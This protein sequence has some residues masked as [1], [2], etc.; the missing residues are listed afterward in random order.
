MPTVLRVFCVSC[1]RETN[2]SA[3]HEVKKN[4]NDEEAEIWAEGKWQIIQCNGCDAIS[5]REVWVN[6]EDVHPEYGPVENITLYPLRGKDVHSIKPF[7]NVPLR[8]RNIYREMVDAFNG[9]MY[10]LCA[11][12]L[13]AI[14]E[15]IC[16]NEG[17]VDGPVEEVTASLSTPKR[18]RNLQGKISGL[19]EKGH[20]TKKHAE[21]LNEHR[22]LG[23]DALH[24]LDQ[25]S[26][27]ELVIAIDIIEHTL[28]NIYELTEKASDLRYIKSRRKKK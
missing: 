17:V 5:F 4:F 24:S 18:R 25:P 21:T 27:D 16:S 22:F 26:K 10:V 9:G 2:H 12:G 1:N 20:L 15:G 28:F 14:I 3:I 8:V 23:N 11:G 19:H 6:S 7:Y 13:R